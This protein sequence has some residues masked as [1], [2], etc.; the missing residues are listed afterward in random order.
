MRIKVLR[1]NSADDHTNSIIFIDGVFECYGL[2]DEFRAD[3]VKGET[4]IPNGIYDIK[5]RAVGGFHTRYLKRYGKSFHKGM[6][7]VM[8][9]P[10]F[11]YILLHSGNTDNDTAGC[12]LLGDGNSRGENFISQSRPAYNRLYPKVR[13]AILRGQKVTI[14]YYT[15]A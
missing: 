4:R 6:L 9:V 15:V 10:N 5:F 14:E 2:E 11:E 7:Q 12:L 3:K 8:N 13:N 1:Y